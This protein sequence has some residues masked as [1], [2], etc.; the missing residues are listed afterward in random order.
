MNSKTLAMYFV[1]EIAWKYILY[2]HFPDSYG[3]ISY[4]ILYSVTSVYTFQLPKQKTLPKHRVRHSVANQTW[5]LVTFSLTRVQ[6][7]QLENKVK[8]IWH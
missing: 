4:L 7:K 8:E 2:T 6:A 3:L 1:W 5:I